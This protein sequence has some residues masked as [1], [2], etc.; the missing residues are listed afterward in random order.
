M[1]V[2]LNVTGASLREPTDWHHIVWRKVYRNVRRLQVR[3]V[4]AFQEGKIR[5]AR[6]LQII[7]TRSFGGKALAV[8]RVTENKGRRTPGIDGE[9]R[10]TPEKK[11]EGIRSLRSEGYRSTPLRRI[12][13]PESNNKRRPLG[14]PIMKDRAFQALHK[15]ASEPIAEETADRNSYGFRMERST[16]DAIEQIFTCLSRKTSAMWIFEADIKSCFDKISHEWLLRN[17]PMNK[18]M[19]KQWLRA[20]FMEKSTFRKT[21]EGTPQGGIIS[22]ILSNMASDGLEQKLQEE[23]SPKDKV[24]FIRFADDFVVT[25][26]TK[27]L[28]EER[29]VPIVRE[30]IEKRGLSLSEKK[31]KITHIREGFDFLGHNIRKFGKGKLIISPSEKNFRNCLDKIREI[32]KKSHNTN[33]ADL[34]CKLN[35][36][37]RGWANYQRHVVSKAAFGRLDYEITKSIRRSV[38][39]KHPRKS[40]KWVRSKYFRMTEQGRDWCFFGR[41]DGKEAYLFHA[42]KVP[43]R[44]HIKIKGEVNPYDLKWEEY[45][46]ERKHKMTSSNFR[47][48]GMLELWKEQDG[49]CP[50]CNQPITIEEGWHNHHI[51]W[52]VCGGSDVPANRILMHPNC[53]RQVHSLKLKVEKPRPQKDVRKA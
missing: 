51:K 5:K 47:N 48:K 12:Y 32:I 4:K 2:T 18:N 16:A 30:H 8:R 38:R 29:A 6:A 43:I 44:R 26:A 33:P 24:H 15:L 36:I 20:G 27:E 21:E 19:L 31:T 9:I 50:V 22:P 49:K 35:P 17:V 42:M 37:I 53:H 3:I 7:L 39:R 25:G 10:N 13:I 46:K 11:T 41:K 45:L 40:R 23:F 52:K 1:G 14:I 34:I 28:I